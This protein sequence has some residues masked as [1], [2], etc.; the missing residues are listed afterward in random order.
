MKAPRWSATV[1][2]ADAEP[3][4]DHDVPFCTEECKSHDG[5]RCQLMGMRPGNI[6]EPAVVGMAAALDSAGDAGTGEGT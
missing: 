2:P 4:W 1:V 3:D 6:C 5:K